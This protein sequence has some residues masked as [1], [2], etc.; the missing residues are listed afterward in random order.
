MSLRTEDKEPLV[1]MFLRGESVTDISAFFAV[2]RTTVEQVLR[3]AI[4]QL[5]RL[6]TTV[7]Q[8]NT[9]DPSK[10]QVILTP[11]QRTLL[12]DMRAHLQKPVRMKQPA[13]LFPAKQ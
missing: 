4:Q 2:T 7:Y 13:T 5:A 9:V 3:E 8:M 12:E 1:T 6:A 11:E 10:E